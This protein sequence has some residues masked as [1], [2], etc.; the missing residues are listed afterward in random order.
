MLDRDLA[1][2][3]QV[4]TAALN[5]ALRRNRERFPSALLQNSVV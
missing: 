5:Q 3:Y 2:L 4:T 1:E